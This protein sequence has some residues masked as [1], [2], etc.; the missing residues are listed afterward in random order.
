MTGFPFKVAAGCFA[1][2][3]V[4]LLTVP[5]VHAQR[6]AEGS[7]AAAYV[8]VDAESVALQGVTL[9]DGTGGPVLR[10]QTIVIE[11]NRITAVGPLRATSAFPTAPSCSTS[12][13]T[14]SCPA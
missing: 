8:A 1:S 6:P 5:P 2:L 9:V 7:E 3:C 12:P 11:G 4:L 13:D 14:P 10:D